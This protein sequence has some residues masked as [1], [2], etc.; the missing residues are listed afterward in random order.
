MDYS[1]D[2]NFVIFNV[3]E[4]NKVTFENLLQDNKNT[5]RK[6]ID[7]TKTFIGWW[8]GNTPSFIN[9]LTTKSKIYTYEELILVLEGLEWTVPYN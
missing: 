2:T 9:N 3:S 7:M 4:L 6:S 5:V 1:L 8:K